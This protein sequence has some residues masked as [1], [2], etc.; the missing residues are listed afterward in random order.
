[1]GKQLRNLREDAR[2][3]DNHA[4]DAIRYAFMHI[5]K[6]G[7]TARLSDVYNLED[8]RTASDS[9][10]DTSGTTASGFFQSDALRF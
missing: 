3:H 6:L 1:M 8:L 4:L 5:F 10:F 2:Q 9:I 7:A